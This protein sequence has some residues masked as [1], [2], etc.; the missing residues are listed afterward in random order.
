MQEEE[1]ESGIIS[2][3]VYWSYITVAYIGVLIPIILLAQKLFHIL[4]IS[5][6]YWMAWATPTTKDQMSIISYYHPNVVYIA[7]AIESSFCILVRSIV[8]SLA[9][10][11]NSNHLFNDM[12]R[13]M[14]HAPMSFFDATPTGRILNWLS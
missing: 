9:R 12:H 2:A 11:K 5:S 7:L 8:T 10:L 3:W 13:C 4:Q 6:N 14:F 1:R